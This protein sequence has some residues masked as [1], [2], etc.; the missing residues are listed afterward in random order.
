MKSH[1]SPEILIDIQD[2]KKSFK[3]HRVQELLVLDQVNFSI[4]K[5]DIV[6]ILGK[7]GS[8]KSTLLRIIAGLINATSGQ[9]L[10]RDQP[11]TQPIP[12]L[13]MVFQPSAFCF[14]ALVDGV[15]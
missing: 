15:G 7:S 13:T 11:I 2:I 5:G 10:Y 3:K 6:A 4:A 8:G 12:G 1:D 14:I 9:V